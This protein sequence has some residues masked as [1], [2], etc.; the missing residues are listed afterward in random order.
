MEEQL[1]D[2]AAEVGFENLERLERQEEFMTI[3]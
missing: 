2:D 3:L 1:N